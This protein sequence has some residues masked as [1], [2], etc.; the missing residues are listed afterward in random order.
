MG[1]SEKELLD[2]LKIHIEKYGYP[3]SKRGTFR[4]KFGLPSY[5]TYMK[6][7]GDNLIEI[8][9]LCGYKLTEKEKYQIVHRGGKSNNISKEEAIKVIQYMQ[10]NL[11]RPLMYDDFRNPT[12]DT[13]GIA[14]IRNIWGSLNKMKE[15]LDLQINQENMIDK[16]RS[17]NQSKEDI[18]NVCNIIYKKENRRII[19]TKDI[20]K[21]CRVNFW[22]YS[23]V[24]K[25]HNTT[26]RKY[27]ESLGF[28]YKKEGT[29]LNHLFK[30]GEKVRSQY[31]LDF[32][33]Y[34]R[35]DLKMQY[36]KDYFR[37]VKY[38]SFVKDYKNSMDCDYVI[39]YKNKIIYIEIAGMLRDLHNYYYND[40]F[41]TKSKTKENYRQKLIKKEEMLKSINAEYY[42]LFPI[43]KNGQSILDW[44]L[45]NRIFNVYD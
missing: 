22:S 1:Y 2:L 32:S 7:F 38:K 11:D 33:N 31:E 9:E 23:K 29:G 4:N 21:Y 10:S 30:D 3:K 14:T 40:K 42:I 18:K 17:I 8:I 12:K 5:T 37:D 28:Q 6:C 27:I 24:F 41:I 43:K 39:N 26:L 35:D 25:K 19:T 20:K 16:T 34:L 44:D 13:I 36:N 15:D 45:I